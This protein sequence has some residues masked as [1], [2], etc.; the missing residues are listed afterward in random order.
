MYLLTCPFCQ[1]IEKEREEL[2]KPAIAELAKVAV[3]ARERE[4]LWYS[5]WVKC[6]VSGCLDEVAMLPS[7]KM[8][9]VHMCPAHRMNYLAEKKRL[10]QKGYRV[11]RR[12]RDQF[13]P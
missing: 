9:T 13:V 3:K 12:A 10:K 7:G 1:I 8:P 6:D 2:L 5:A 11:R 4:D